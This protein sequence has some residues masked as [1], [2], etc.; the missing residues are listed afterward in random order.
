MYTSYMPFVN[1]YLKQN[2]TNNLLKIREIIQFA[3]FANLNEPQRPLR[4]TVSLGVSEYKG[5]QTIESF[6]NSA[7]DALYQAKSAGR[8]R[9]VGGK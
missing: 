6:I 2:N 1:I 4:I 8:N 9:S 7:D 3:E 5:N